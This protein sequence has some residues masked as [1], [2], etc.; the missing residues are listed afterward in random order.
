MTVQHDAHDPGV[1]GNL[2]EILDRLVTG[3][4][5]DV[6]FGPVV[7]AG[8]TTVIPCARVRVGLG[9]GGGAAV[10][11]G[12]PGEGGGGGAGLRAD[13]VAAI[14]VRPGGVTVAPVR[15]PRSLALAALAGALAALLLTRR[16]RAGS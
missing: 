11:E 2:R 6:V 10:D 12:A 16:R 9:M 13:P 8:D 5:P 15:R 1:P 4:G 3:A 7:Q 14:V